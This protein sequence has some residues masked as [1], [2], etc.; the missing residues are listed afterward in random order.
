VWLFGDGASMPYRVL[1]LMFTFLGS[2]VTSTNILNF[3]DLMILGMA[4]PNLIGVYLLH[5]KVR[6]AIDDYWRRLHAGE[7]VVYR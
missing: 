3:G 1:F 2:I 6:A 7:F 4:L 5:G